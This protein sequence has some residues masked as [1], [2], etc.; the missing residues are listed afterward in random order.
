MSVSRNRASAEFILAGPSD[1][2]FA[3]LDSGG[4][5]EQGAGSGAGAGV[6]GG[7]E[8]R[9]VAE[10]EAETAAAGATGAPVKAT[11]TVAGAIGAAS[12]VASEAGNSSASNSSSR[13]GSSSTSGTAD[14]SRNAGTSCTFGNSDE[15][16]VEVGV[17]ARRP[18][19]WL[20]E[21]RPAGHREASFDARDPPDVPSPI[22]PSALD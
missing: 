13:S 5:G 9:P 1:T 8:A 18:R 15:V 19:I 12:G 20:Q 14:G 3:P 17:A 2:F 10:G 7:A 6:A 21:V 11:G 16:G 22:R 4:A